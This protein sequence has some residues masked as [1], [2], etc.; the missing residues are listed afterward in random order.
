MYYV[1]VKMYYVS[2]KLVQFINIWK[3]HLIRNE[4]VDITYMNLA[5][6]RHVYQAFLSFRQCHPIL[7]KHTDGGSDVL[8]TVL[9]S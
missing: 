3:I 1:S 6:I 5:Q 7:A 8:N 4:L 2:V 9:M